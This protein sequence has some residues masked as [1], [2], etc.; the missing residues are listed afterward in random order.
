MKRVA[1]FKITNVLT[2]T[3]GVVFLA[4]TVLLVLLFNQ[5]MKQQALI[6]AEAKARILIDRNLATHAYFS[7][8]LKPRLFAWTAPFRTPEYFDP[9]W[10]SSTY[11]IRGI[12]KYFSSLNPAGYYLKDAAVNAR[13]PENEADDYER[14]F[15]DKLR[16]DPKLTSHAEIRT[17]AGKHYL[18]VMRRGESM[19]ASCLRCHSVPENAP[20]DMMK[21]YETDRS[22]NRKA[23]DLVSVISL[24]IPLDDAYEGMYRTFIKLSLLLAILLALL[25]ALQT[26]MYRRYLVRP[27]AMIREKAKAIAAGDEHLGEQIPVQV[28]REFRELA[29]AFNEMSLR[30]RQGRD[31]LEDRVA[32]RTRELNAANEQLEREVAQRR[33]AEDNLRERNKELRCLYAIAD[34]M[35]KNAIMEETLQEIADVIPEGY[36]YPEFA[37]ARIILKDQEFK[38]GNFLET[39][40][41]MSAEI[42][43]QGEALGM[44]EVCY[45]KEKPVRDEGPFV[46]EERS[47]LNTIAEYLGRAIEHRQAVAQMKASEEQVRLLLNSTGEAIYGIDLQGNCTFANQSCLRMLGYEAT[48]QLLGKNMHRLIHHSYADGSPMANEVCRIYKAFR[49]GKGVHVDDEVLWRADGSSFPAEYFSYPQIVDGKVSGAVVAFHDITKRKKDEEILRESERKYRE[50]SIVDNLSH[51]YNSRHFFNQLQIEVERIKRYG[52]PLT[53]ILLDIDNFKNYNDLYGHIEGDQVISRLGKVIKRCLRRTDSAYRYGGEEFTILL[54]STKIKDGFVSAERIRTEFKK[55]TFSPLPE[56][57]VR[58]TLSI[59]IGQYRSDEDVK[60]FVQRVDRFMYQ[61]KR[62]GKDRICAEAVADH[63]DG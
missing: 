56:K 7:H 28:G 14:A 35:E 42:I 49:E 30:L 5:S 60:G 58:L 33:V 37:C 1:D 38:T 11:A 8:E 34:I 62:D 40:W 47:L 52:E 19:E 26:Y 54:P 32:D 17:L 29:S 36:Y 16:K 20:Q 39:G 55:E 12:H 31:Y 21:H 51:L 46:K 4:V 2:F 41:R 6:E 48:D 24:R 3:I 57:S 25:F 13:S 9:V 53:L 63:L 59:G 44:V 18:A 45:L 50:L 27:L 61:A 43:V 10:M 15:L 22:F 23:G